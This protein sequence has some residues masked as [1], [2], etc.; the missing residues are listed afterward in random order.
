MIW[1]HFKTTKKISPYH[2]AIVLSDLGHFSVKNWWC[3]QQVKREI[4]FAQTFVEK[5]ILN[6]QYIFKKKK[7]TPKVNHVVI[8]AFR[9]EGVESWGL[10]LYRYYSHISKR[11]F[12]FH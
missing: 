12:N 5:A 1:T 9:D 8:P 6:L 7:H 3:R 2:V 11:Y 10:V 4:K